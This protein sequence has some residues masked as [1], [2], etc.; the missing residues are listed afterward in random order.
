MT[1]RFLSSVAHSHC[2]KVSEGEGGLLDSSHSI[3]ESHRPSGLESNRCDDIQDH[4]S[5]TDSHVYTHES[6]NS[7]DDN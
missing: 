5:A 4:I 1:S 6:G 2:S 3:R 7:D